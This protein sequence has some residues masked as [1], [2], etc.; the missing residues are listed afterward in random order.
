MD[1]Y[2]LRGRLAASACDGTDAEYSLALGTRLPDGRP[3]D[4]A[5]KLLTHM[6]PHMEVAPEEGVKTS[7]SLPYVLHIPYE[8]AVADFERYALGR[9][10]DRDGTV[11]SARFVIPFRGHRGTPARRAFWK[12]EL[13]KHAGRWVEATLEAQR[14]CFTVKGIKRVGTRLVICAIEPLA[15]A[16]P[17]LVA[18]P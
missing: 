7:L 10:G 4:S 14:Y 16:A 8:Q 3:D 15:L 1:A 2:T 6:P 11:C 17:R 5:A 9:H 18:A 13:A 12:T